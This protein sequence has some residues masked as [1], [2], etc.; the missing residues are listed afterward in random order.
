MTI[1][2]LTGVPGVGKTAVAASLQAEAPDIV[3]ALGFGRLVF[4]AVRARLAKA[5]DYDYFRAH[6]ADLVG[7]AD[8]AAATSDLLATAAAVDARSQLLILDSHA[9]SYE[10]YGFRG[11]PDS[12]D[13]LRKLSYSLIVHLHAEPSVVLRRLAHRSGTNGSELGPSDVATISQ[14]QLSASVFYA[15]TLGCPLHVVGAGDDLPTVVCRVRS[16]LGV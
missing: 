6:S 14:L 13:V 11:T 5:I 15:A 12:P 10:N 4:A 2:L 16:V 3:Q 1:A 8:I 7:S 9:V